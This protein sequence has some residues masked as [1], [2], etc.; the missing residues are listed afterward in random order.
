MKNIFLMFVFIALLSVVGFSANEKEVDVVFYTDVTPPEAEALIIENAENEHFVILDVRTPS[1]FNAGHIDGATNVNCNASDFEEKMNRFNKND[2]FL[3][4][5]ASGGRSSSA[6]KKMKAW[7]FT[8][9]YHLK[10]GYNGWKR[11]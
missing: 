10:Q 1:E 5:C 2:I 8:K 4:Y 7:G 6:L 11:R 9:I 3:L